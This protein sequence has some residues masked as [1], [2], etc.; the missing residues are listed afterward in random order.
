MDR[1]G[2]SLRLKDARQP[3]LS[4]MIPRGRYAQY[5]SI[6]RSTP[7]IT[8][9]KVDLPENVQTSPNPKHAYRL[10]NGISVDGL[11]RPIPPKA[12]SR[13][14]PSRK[15]ETPITIQPSQIEAS[16]IKSPK[17][18]KGSTGLY[19]AALLIFVGGGYVSFNSWQLN[20]KLAAQATILEKKNGDATAPKGLDDGNVPS[21]D[22]P[23]GIDYESLLKRH[24]APANDPKTIK[25]PA[26]SVHARI[27]EMGLTQNGNIQAP[28]SIFDAG[29][30]KNSA[31]LG[32]NGVTF[33]DGHVFGTTRPAV[34]SK[35][36]DLKANDTIEITRGD[37]TKFT[38]KIREQKTYNV[39]DINMNELLK[40]RGGGSE[41]VLMTCHGPYTAQGAYT[42]RYVLFATLVKE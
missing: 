29:W 1:Q 34:F 39:D 26:I 24:S 6:N 25:I 31:R 5:T 30:Y 36:K 19:I 17:T 2:Q 8:L 11:M 15:V 27:L 41:L 16:Q 13:H 28:N 38:Y 22:L 40:G 35:L 23:Q 42:E 9:R 32:E 20:K 10:K 21:E 4:S 33:I 12:Q 14:K 3:S 18:N 37:N 7:N